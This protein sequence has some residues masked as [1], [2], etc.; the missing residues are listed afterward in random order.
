MRDKSFRRKTEKY[1]KKRP[2]SSDASESSVAGSEINMRRKKSS[3]ESLFSECDSFTKFT[4][5]MAEQNMRE[6]KSRKYS[7]YVFDTLH[8][9]LYIAL[10]TFC[11][12]SWTLLMI[13]F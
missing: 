8:F 4:L 3:S 13:I 2:E 10:D 5:E 11:Q 12:K 6:E 7:N 9:T 1:A